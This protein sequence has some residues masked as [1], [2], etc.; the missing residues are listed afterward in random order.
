MRSHSFARNALLTIAFVCLLLSGAGCE[1]IIENA[2]DSRD[3]DR[4]VRS[5]KERGYSTRDAHRNAHYDQIWD[6]Y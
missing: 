4:R 5:Y 6:S 1:T 3:Y 2:L